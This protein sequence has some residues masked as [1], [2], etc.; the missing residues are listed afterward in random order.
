METV[1][2][3]DL[4]PLDVGGATP[5]VV[6]LFA[7][8]AASLT[9]LARFYL[10]DRTAAEDLVQEAFIRLSRSAGRIR[11]RGNAAAYLR[12]IVINLARDHNRRGLVSLRHRPSAL[13]DAP[14]AEEDAHTRAERQEVIDALRALPRRQRDCVTLRYY[15]DLSIPDIAETLGLSANT[16]KTHLQR[17]MASLATTLEGTR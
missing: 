1:A 7:Q 12:S 6:D 16:V 13:P 15:L 3:I 2:E 8:E 10:D 14:S 9:R 17:G 11:Q 5:D 4:K